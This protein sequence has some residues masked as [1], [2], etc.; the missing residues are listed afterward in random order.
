MTDT[1]WFR[2]KTTRTGFYEADACTGFS[3]FFLTSWRIT[4][5]PLTFAASDGKKIFSVSFRFP[6]LLFDAFVVFPGASR[7][8]RIFLKLWNFR[9]LCW[10]LKFGIWRMLPLFYTEDP[11]FSC[12][13]MILATIKQAFSIVAKTVE[14]QPKK[15]LSSLKIVSKNKPC[16]K[17]FW[18]SI[19]L[20]DAHIW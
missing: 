15:K 8:C 19:C 6:E 5:T 18:S 17:H 9:K 3:N 16:W 13:F 20:G 11:F 14:V 4:C 7:T 2:R 10:G 1:K 12:I